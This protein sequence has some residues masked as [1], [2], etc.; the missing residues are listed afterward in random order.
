M[1]KLKTR[2]HLI[3]FYW[4]LLIQISPFFSK[5]VQS[6]FTI[7][8]NLIVKKS[9]EDSKKLNN[10]EKFSR[11]SEINPLEKLINDDFKN[12]SPKILDLVAL[13]KNNAESFS[14]DIESNIQYE[15]DNIYYA[16]GEA[17]IYFSN[18]NLK[19]DLI[20]YDRLNKIIFATGNVKFYKGNQFFQAS[21]LSYNLKEDKGF[22]KKVY[23]VID[24]R[25]FDKDYKVNLNQFV[26]NEVL[27]NQ[28]IPVEDIEYINSATLGLVNDFERNKKFNITDLNLN[29]PQIT[30]WRFKTERIDFKSDELRSSN[31]FFTNDAF[32]KPQFILQSKNFS[33]EI[34]NDR[35]KL[36]SRNSWII[37]DNKVKFPIGRRTIFDRDPLT[38]W[39]IG[40]DFMDKDGY[41]IFR[42][43][44]VRKVFGNYNLKLQPYFLAQRAIKGNTKSFSAPNTSI[45]SSKVKNETDF[46]DYF[47]LDIDFSGK[48][49]TWDLDS[50]IS[51]NSLNVDRL[52]Q[53]VR[54]KIT[55]KKRIDLNKRKINIQES[56]NQSFNDYSSSKDIDNNLIPV[57]EEL[58]YKLFDDDLNVKLEENNNVDTYNNFLDFQIYNIYRENVEKGFGTEEIYFA[59]GITLANS[60]FWVNDQNSSR[61]S[62]IY[63]LGN[64]NSKSRTEN[65]LKNLTRNV[66][67]AQYDYSFPIWKK[68]KVKERIDES[69]IYTPTVLNESI[70]WVTNLQSGL[71]L[72]SDGSTQKGIKLNSGPIFT[73]GSLKRNF[74][75]Y[76]VLRIN[77]S[78]GI[79]SGNSPFAF[80]NI[81][82]NSSLYFGLQQQIIG[83]VV[84][85][86][87]TSLNMDTGSYSEPNYALDI[88]RRAYSIGA[89]YTS[90]SESLGLRFNI[91][92]FDYAGSGTKF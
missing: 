37:L 17:T 42:G 90:S 67:V 5:A 54:S 8:K 71:Y 40:A 75:D 25:T 59:N 47:A 66:F 14:V 88:K 28:E 19:A 82:E 77:G 68:N 86:Y 23:G 72:Y 57:N 49:N 85:S 60:K 70:E 61:F 32:N 4:L 11:L 13:E 10:Y 16:E 45:L 92:N 55:L 41:Y 34:I 43:N 64:F 78:Y 51:F 79:K 20:T 6:E 83:P 7:E 26:E 30:K 50:E 27:V 73:L 35:L 56:N 87:E 53:S 63:D 84:F 76:T 91:F 33:G 52:D 9:S 3:F 39:G 29:V 81:G 62:L 24:V 44:D 89:F 21:E 12:L 31:I 22:I 1:I 18:A 58:E 48:L 74:L 38:K 46:L 80:D 69:Y 2:K 15:K 36:V 65:E